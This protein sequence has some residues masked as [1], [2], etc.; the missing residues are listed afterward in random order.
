MPHYLLTGAGFSRNWGGMLADDVFGY[1]LGCEDLDDETRRLLFQR[2]SVK[3][4]FEDV[5]ADLQ[6]ARGA[7]GQ[8]RHKA[9][10]T[11]LVGMFNEMGLAFMQRELEFSNIPDVRYSLTSF[12]MRFDAIFTLNQDTL[13]EQKYIPVVGG[14]VRWGRAHLPGLKLLGNPILTGSIHDRIAPMEPNPSDFKLDT[15][16]QP[17][18][19]LH[20]SCNWNDGP[21]GECILIMGG[22]KA[23]SIGQFPILTWYHEQF[24]QALRK[25]GARLMVVGYSF[26][27]AHINGIII[28]AMK[29]GDLKIFLIDPAGEKILDKRDPRAQ[30]QDRPGELMEV[31]TPR[32]VG[33]S[34]RPI[35]TTFNNDI[36][37]HGNLSRFLKE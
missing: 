34:T 20:G 18:I 11:A 36:V 1:L 25:P 7:A 17:Y 29:S 33:M 37:E 6:R 23:V 35:S 2:R 22:Q 14:G 10:V 9:L 31:V 16:V 5:L 13:L 15:N 3:G 21:A 28:N 30:I 27:D 4:G 24:E 26:G 12:L 32:I 8:Q 19:K